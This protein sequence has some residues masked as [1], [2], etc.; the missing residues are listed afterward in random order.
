MPNSLMVI[1]PYYENGTWVFDDQ[2]KDLCKE[3]F[4]DGAPEIIDAA[5]QHITNAK[6]GFRLMFSAGPFPSHQLVLGWK[7]EDMGGNWYSV[8]TPS[9]LNG[10]E[11]WLCPALFKYFDTAPKKIYCSAEPLD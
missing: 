5:T 2:T 10:M 9:A 4:V 7:S 11:G 8:E 3:P 6:E 1:C